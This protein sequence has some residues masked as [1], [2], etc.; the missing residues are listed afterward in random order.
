MERSR[1]ARVVLLG[2][3][4]RG[5]L[6][7]AVFAVSVVG[8]SCARERHPGSGGQPPRAAPGPAGACGMYLFTQPSCEA[9]LDQGCCAQQQNCAADAACARII[10]CWNDC[11]LKRA[12]EGCNCFNN[13]A[14][15]GQQTP[16]LQLF[17]YVADCS[18]NINYPQG[19]ACE[20][21][22]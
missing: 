4:R 22:C 21:G 12:T 14:P 20:T 18:K 17:G 1:R 15:Q 6:V 5:V 19:I 11:E 7:T 3:L 13:C 9:A 2:A 10:Q 8:A 16:G